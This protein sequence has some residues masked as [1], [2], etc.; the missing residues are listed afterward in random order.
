[1]GHDASSDPLSR[2]KLRGPRRIRRGSTG[3]NLVA[4]SR[5]QPSGQLE[6]IEQSRRARPDAS[7][8]GSSTSRQRSTKRFVSTW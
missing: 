6:E 8:K 3:G 1:M 4:P 2:S 7:G 5:D